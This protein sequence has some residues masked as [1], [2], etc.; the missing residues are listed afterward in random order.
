MSPS[1]GQDAKLD[2]AE[3]VPAESAVE[4][5]K[6]EYAILIYFPGQAANSGPHKP[7]CYRQHGMFHDFLATP[8]DHFIEVSSHA[9]G[10]YYRYVNDCKRP[11]PKNAAHL[12]EIIFNNLNIGNM[13]EDVGGDAEI[14]SLIW[15]RDNWF[16]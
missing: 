16:L 4:L 3:T 11:R 12:A 14:T 1:P 6:T 8:Q 2:R 15:N 9:V 7:A 5:D 13:L 10:P